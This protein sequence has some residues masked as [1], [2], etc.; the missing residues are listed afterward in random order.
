V[1]ISGI[2]LEPDRRR[3]A[4]A[5]VPLTRRSPAPR[6]SPLGGSNDPATRPAASID[7]RHG[8]QLEETT[9]S[10]R[11]MHGTEQVLSS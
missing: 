8:L 1:R 3:Q 6:S 7:P 4:G 10:V 2:A 11:R 5:K 9:S